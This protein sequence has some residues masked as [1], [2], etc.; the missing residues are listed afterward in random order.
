MVP[1]RRSGLQSTLYSFPKD[2]EERKMEMDGLE[3]G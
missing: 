3:R 1:A 2:A